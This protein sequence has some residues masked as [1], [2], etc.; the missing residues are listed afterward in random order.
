MERADGMTR[1]I[2]VHY[3]LS[4]DKSLSGNSGW[5]PVLELYTSLSAE[6]HES[7]Q[8]NIPAVL[9]KLLIGED[10]LNSLQVIVSRAR[11]NARG[12]QDQLTKE[13]WEQVNQ[14]YHMV[15]D[16]SLKIRLN[17]NEAMA[18]IEN[19]SNQ[20]VVFAGI[21]DITMERG[22]GWN[23]MNLGKFIERCLQ[24]ISIV[25]KE[26][27][28]ITEHGVDARDILQWRYLLLC[29][30]GYE[31]HLKNYRSQEHEKNVMDQVLLNE[32]FPHSV[33]YSLTRINYYLEN[34][35][36]IHGEVN[37]SLARDFGRLYS[38]VKY[39][40]L[41]SFTVQ[42]LREFLQELANDLGDFTRELSQHY[43]NYS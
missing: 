5:K 27:E 1:L 15:N 6:V 4:M 40:E 14:M 26:L 42:S 23:F 19:F 34:I 7:I 8:H 2:H 35:R 12:A 10:N 21:T 25:N 17:T 16:H 37:I 24:T 28:I 20:T 22:L 9:K 11:E 36:I 43:F 29:L 41:Q 31:M 33:I 38:K 32:N 13:V 39:M 30:S 3:I 18:I